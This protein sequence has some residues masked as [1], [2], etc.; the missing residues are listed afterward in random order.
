MHVLCSYMKNSSLPK[1]KGGCGKKGE[2]I[3][4]QAMRIKSTGNDVSLEFDQD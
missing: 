1:A 4:M 2:G 3:Q